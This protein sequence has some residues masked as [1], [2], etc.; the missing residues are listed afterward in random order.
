MKLVGIRKHTFC[1]IHSPFIQLTDFE[2]FISITV[3][4]RPEC[5][6][7]KAMPK[8]LQS[9]V[10]LMCSLLRTDILRCTLICKPYFVSL[11]YLNAFK[12]QACLNLKYQHS[13]METV[14]FTRSDVETGYSELEFCGFPQ[15]FRENR[16]TV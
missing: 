16:H 11:F 12:T 15:L 7:L 13:F 9:V 4:I 10:K 6:Q 2:K 8:L 1:V 5:A 14:C 3:H